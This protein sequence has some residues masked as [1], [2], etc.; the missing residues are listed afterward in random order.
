M[1][2]NLSGTLTVQ[3]IQGRR[4]PFKTAKLATSIGTFDVKNP[5]LKQFEPGEYQGNFII[6]QLKVKA[7]EWGGGATSY[8]DAALDW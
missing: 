7:Y 8:L 1:S 5:I 3:V 6:E 2:I 4:G